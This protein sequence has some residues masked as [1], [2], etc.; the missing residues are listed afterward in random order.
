MKTALLDRRKLKIAYEDVGT[1]ETLLLLHAFPLDREMWQPQLDGLADS[2]RLIAPDYPGFG[3]SSA[4]EEGFTIE[5]LAEVM[6][7]FLDVIGVTGT[8]VVVG[9]SM[10]GYVA[11]AMARQQRQ[12]L[13]GLILADTKAESDDETGKAG[14]DAMCSVAREKGAAGVIDQ[15]LPKLLGTTAQ[16]DV[17]ERVRVIASRQDPVAIVGALMALRDRPDATSGLEQI[18]VPA[19]VLVGEDDAIT[20]PAVAQSL[21][22]RIMGSNRVVIAGAG[23][24]S[25]L[26]APEAFNAEIRKFVRR[27]ATG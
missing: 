2:Y 13:R 7:D 24:L 6:A 11:L 17:V 22:E 16:L 8:V 1:G 20:P 26:E 25:N 5:M 19:L 12:R 21:S 3:D 10:G 15:L 4:A 18:T 27:P 23:H 9:L 14:R